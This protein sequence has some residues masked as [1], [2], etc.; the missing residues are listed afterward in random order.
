MIGT[1]KAS[2]NEVMSEDAAEDNSLTK[3]KS[4]D[5]G[6]PSRTVLPLFHLSQNLSATALVESIS[7]PTT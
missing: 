4:H 5:L 6:H 7:Q 1:V 3:Q 2:L